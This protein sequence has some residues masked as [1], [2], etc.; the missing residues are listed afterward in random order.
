MAI[1]ISTAPCCWGV[2]DP[3]NPFLPHWEKVLEEASKA[4]YQAIELGPLG[5]LPKEKGI[6]APALSRRG[7][8]VIAG[9]IFDDLVAEIHLPALLDKA[10]EICALVTALPRIPAPGRAALSDPVPGGHRLWARGA[11]L[12]GRAPREG[13][14]AGAIGLGPD[15]RAHRGH[16]RGRRPARRADGDPPARGR[17][18]RVRRRD[19][20]GRGGRL[21][22]AGGPVPRHRSPPVLGHGAA[23]VAPGVRPPPRLRALQGR[24]CRGASADSGGAHTL[25]RSLCAGGDVPIGKGAIDYP[26]VRLLLEEVGYHGFATVEQERDPRNASTSLRD[27]TESLAYLR[28]VG[29]GR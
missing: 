11:R 1:R 2:D 16:L 21:A 3:K 6:L 8:S 25:L 14:A 13:T 15:D 7:L 19:P 20:A 22:A 23:R 18:H 29:F 17:L 9:T 10:Q 28:S 12:R 26:A 24:G 4:G 27:V 5:Y